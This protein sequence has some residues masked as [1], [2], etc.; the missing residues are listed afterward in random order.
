M[1]A[2]HPLKRTR[3]ASYK[4][5]LVGFLHNELN[6]LQ[7]IVS[8]QTFGPGQPIPSGT[9]LRTPKESACVGLKPLVITLLLCLDDDLSN[10]YSRSLVLYHFIRAFGACGG[11]SCC[12]RIG[13]QNIR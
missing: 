13:I 4:L 11:T 10:K 7:D 5:V 2:D 3:L 8:I 9:L 6:W 1:C 12:W